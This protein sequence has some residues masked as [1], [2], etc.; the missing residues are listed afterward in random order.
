MNMYLANICKPTEHTPTHITK[1]GLG[2]H[3]TAGEHGHGS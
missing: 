1:R 3:I 2:A